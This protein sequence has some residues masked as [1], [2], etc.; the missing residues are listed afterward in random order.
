MCKENEE[1]LLPYHL[2]R[3]VET[4]WSDTIQVDPQGALV[5]SREELNQRIGNM[6]GGAENDK[7]RDYFLTIEEPDKLVKAILR[8]IHALSNCVVQF[9]S[10]TGL[11]IMNAQSL[12]SLRNFFQAQGKGKIPLVNFSPTARK[13][14]STALRGSLIDN[15]GLEEIHGELYAVYTGVTHN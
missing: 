14:I 10:T 2:P 13:R 3:I 8:E 1:F 7:E 4:A 11:S 5:L 12:G 15:F 6:R 9:T